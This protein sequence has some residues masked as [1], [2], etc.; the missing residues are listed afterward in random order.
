MRRAQTTQN[1]GNL[2]TA[3]SEW[4]KSTVASSLASAVKSSVIAT[5]FEI[6]HDDEDVASQASY[7]SSNSGPSKIRP[8]H[9][10]E[11]GLNGEPFEC[12]LCHKV[13]QSSDK[14]HEHIEREHGEIKKK[15]RIDVVRSCERQHPMDQ[16]ACC[17]LC[18]KKQHSLTQ[19]R[20]HLGKHHEQLSLFAVPSHMDDDEEGD[21]DDE[22]DDENDEAEAEDLSITSNV[23]HAGSSIGSADAE[24]IEQS[25]VRGQEGN[26]EE[27]G[28]EGIG[29]RG[30]L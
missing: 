18:K 23:A 9:L 24:E 15:A 21:D 2:D 27:G 10:P 11:Q 3:T 14:L 19:L 16:E 12:P 26:N 20:R 28:I 4:V 29:E 8:P 13:F 17:P 5:G 7:A 30:T 22:E 6:T 25:L 1:A